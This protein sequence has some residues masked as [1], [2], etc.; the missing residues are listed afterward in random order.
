MKVAVPVSARPEWKVSRSKWLFVRE[1]RTVTA[2][3]EIITAFRDGQVTL[4]S[5]RRME[6]FTNALQE[7]GYQGIHKGD[8]VIHSMD[9][10]AGAIGVSDSDGKASPVVNAYSPREGVEPRYY[11]YVLRELARSGFITS[12]AKGI[13]ERS[14]AFDNEMFRSLML[15]SPPLDEQRAIADYLD[16]E[17]AR[18]DALVEKKQRMIQLLI[19]R[20]DAFI[21]RQVL[22]GEDGPG[23]EWANGIGAD[24]HM[25]RLGSV[26]RI[27]GE[28][29]D[30]IHETQ[31]LSLTADRGVILYE[32]KGDIGNKASDDISRYSVVHQGDIVVNSMNVVIGSVG[33]SRY[34]GVLSPVYYV[35]CPVDSTKVDVRFL[36]Y[37]FRIR[38]FQQQLRRLGYGILEHRLRIPWVNLKTQMMALPPLET[39]SEVAD[40]LVGAER[41]NMAQ[42]ESLIRSIALLHERREALITAAVTG[43]L[44]IPG[45]AA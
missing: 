18:I 2:T 37:H 28:R 23:P 13:R 45:V 44:K 8:L 5:N 26:L 24:R 30:P 32:D 21:E 36:A 19:S 42:R 39:Q 25:A 12:L 40:L 14:T 9:G 35:L 33:L 7:I 6:G 34:R 20:M 27:R 31:I 43:E 17:T 38:A 3:D 29:N 15:P 41:S 22:G 4:R 1:Q 11:A 16:A 10:F